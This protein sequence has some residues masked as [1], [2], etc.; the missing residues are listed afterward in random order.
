MQGIK[1]FP[2]MLHSLSSCQHFITEAAWNSVLTCVCI[3][4]LSSVPGCLQAWASD[5]ASILQFI[6]DQGDNLCVKPLTQLR[7]CSIWLFSVKHCTN[8]HKKTFF[9]ECYLSW[10]RVH[11]VCFFVL[12]SKIYFHAT[13][14]LGTCYYYAARL[15]SQEAELSPCW[16]RYAGAC[17]GHC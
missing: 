1:W 13:N 14:S 17:H 4:E 6:V 11:I 10:S 5:I 2:N 9:L 7:S 3:L 8:V 15:L 12:H 16:D